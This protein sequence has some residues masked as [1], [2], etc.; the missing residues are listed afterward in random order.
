MDPFD[1]LANLKISPK[2]VYRKVTII[3]PVYNEERTIKTL[4]E[5]VQSAPTSGLEKQIILVDDG[6]RD[7][8]VDILKPLAGPSLEV[9]FHER[10]LG[11]THA[12]YT[13]FRAATGDIIIVQDA[14]LEYDP[15]EYQLLILP[16]LNEKADVVYGSRYLK[17]SNRQVPRF[18]H[19]F[20]NKV[21]TYIS[22]SLSNIY[23][24][25]V[26]TCYKAFNRKV[27]TEV[28]LGLSSKRFGFDAEFTAKIARKPYKIIEVP[29]SYYPRTHARGKH[30]SLFDQ[31]EALWYIVRYNLFP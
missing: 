2:A 16:F 28:G 23:L 25:D 8:T 21:Y 11:K 12:L 7:G 27:L 6:S 4:V 13:G 1:E 19:T 10:N 3:I 14:D 18:W 30:M 31:L 17:S 26:Y 9:I 5:I 22:N 20:F 15:F 24:T 29:V